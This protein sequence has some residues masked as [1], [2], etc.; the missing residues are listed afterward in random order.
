MDF[1]NSEIRDGHFFD[2]Y[3][4]REPRMKMALY[5][6]G[7]IIFLFLVFYWIFLASPTNFINKKK[8]YIFVV[9][10]GE[11]IGQVAVDLNKE[12]IIKSPFLFQLIIKTIPGQESVK[13]GKYFF[14]HRQ[15]LLRVIYRLITNKSGFELIEVVFPEGTSVKEMSQIL[16]SKIAGFNS[17]D[18]EKKALPFEGMLFPDTYHFSLDIGSDEIIKAMND[19]FLEK[20]EPFD[21]DI[22]KTKKT[23]DQIVNMAS[24]VEEEGKD[25]LSKQM[26]AG[27]L[28]KR[29]D[30]SMPL[31]VDAVFRYWNGKHSFTLTTEDLR[32]DS[33]YNTYTRKGLPPTPITNP[34]LDSIKA[35]IYP[36]KSNYLY[37]LTGKDGKMYYATTHDEHVLNK[38]KYLK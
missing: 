6:L 19:N 35:T 8:N 32:E 34:G 33:P 14:E 23:L 36:R 24:I 16:S 38:D 18:F 5:H 28:W 21:L 22:K 2:L 11:S 17:K 25:Y 37:Y 15:N 7:I 30:I 31:Q 29:F 27:I 13:A 10:K 1:K 3:G 12:K 20:I 26:I 9:E 4:K